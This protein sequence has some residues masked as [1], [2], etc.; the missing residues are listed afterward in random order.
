MNGGVVAGVVIALLVLLGVGWVLWMRKVS[1]QRT[2]LYIP[3]DSNHF[4]HHAEE[5]GCQRQRKR[6]VLEPLL[7]EDLVR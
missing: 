5:K 7:R 2:R 1:Y 4:A 3:Y 6:T